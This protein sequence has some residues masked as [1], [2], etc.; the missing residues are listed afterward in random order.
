MSSGCHLSSVCPHPPPLTHTHTRLEQIRA[1]K[2]DELFPDELNTPQDVPARERFQK[3][4]G[5][6]SFRSSPWDKLENLPRDYARCSY[7]IVNN[8]H[9]SGVPT[10]CYHC[11]GYFSLRTLLDL[12]RGLFLVWQI[13]MEQWLVACC[14]AD[15]PIT[16]QYFLYYTAGMVCHSAHDRCSSIIL[17]WV[18]VCVCE[19]NRYV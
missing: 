12:A 4:R 7:I 18:C 19:L 9:R 16:L 3:Y 13:P 11:S 10:S 8:R 15:C 6:K 5:L 14:Y 17:R 2:E 1:A